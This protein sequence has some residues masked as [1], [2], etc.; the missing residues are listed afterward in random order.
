MT[1]AME[2]QGQGLGKALRT[3]KGPLI[4]SG[5]HEMH[6]NLVCTRDAKPEIE[7]GLFLPGL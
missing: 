3:R 4:G 2:T 5:Y 6:C 7:I 1:K